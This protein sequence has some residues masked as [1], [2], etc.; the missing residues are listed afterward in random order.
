MSQADLEEQ[1]DSPETVMPPTVSYVVIGVLVVSGLL[2]ALTAGILPS[3]G[4]P[5]EHAHYSYTQHLARDPLP[6]PPR[7][8]DIYTGDDTRPNHLV[9]PPAYHYVMAISYL[10]LR[11]D[12]Q[13]TSVGREADQHGGVTATAM[14]PALRM[15]SLPL[16]AV[17]LL[18]LYQLLGLLVRRRIIP[19]WTT[20]PLAAASSW[21]PAVIFISGTLNND[22]LLRALWPWIAF[23]VMQYAFTGR[24]TYLWSSVT[25]VSL[26]V[27]TKGTFWPFAI[28]AAAT[29]LVVLGKR[30][31]SGFRTALRQHANSANQTW[32]SQLPLVTAVAVA[33]LTIWYL[34]S[35]LFRYG[36]PQPSY[37]TVFGIPITESQFYRASVASRGDHSVTTSAAAIK[38]GI[39]DVVG[40]F[41]GVLGQHERILPA[42]A[43]PETLL[44]ASL[45]VMSLALA[46]WGLQPSRRSARSLTGAALIGTALVFAVTYVTRS[47]R[48]FQV[49]GNF[50][51][52]GRYLIG[53]IDAWLLGS[54][55]LG[56]HYVSTRRSRV[57]RLSA[58]SVLVALMVICVMVLARPMHYF[59]NS[60][61]VHDRAGVDQVV[62]SSAEEASLNQLDF[63]AAPA[64]AATS[65]PAS[66]SGRIL[67]ADSWALPNAEAV[68]VA[69]LP[70]D[71]IGGDCLLVRLHSRSDG[72]GQVEIGIEAEGAQGP[73]IENTS[74]V[75]EMPDG[76]D[77]VDTFISTTTAASSMSI[78]PIADDQPVDILQGFAGVAGCP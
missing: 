70:R 47:W 17:H 6:F 5:D 58:T 26:G 21:A 50:G 77:V 18:G 55:A 48:T 76:V 25:L 31:I 1:R 78:R 29:C 23:V 73:V 16:V 61:Q 3:G 59:A 74:L 34:V 28:V 33:S 27:L 40:S 49:L 67:P 9:H 62:R 20:I 56:W 4:G 37:A 71:A 30:G 13:L 60:L 75:L 68:I 8:E 64:S 10:T 66:R 52:Q 12:D 53:Y 11:I 2:S 39:E 46:I 41:V 65:I 22:V 43:G 14:I 35:M 63:E 72:G 24:L 15:A 36:S 51:A 42:D 54:V 38:A 45:S 69:Q 44:L 19:A 32:L 7:F 57:S